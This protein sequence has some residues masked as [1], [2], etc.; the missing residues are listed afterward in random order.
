MT[1][2]L[3]STFVHQAL[4]S[5]DSPTPRPMKCVVFT[6]SDSRTH[7]NDTSGDLIVQRLLQAGHILVHRAM[8]REDQ[9]LMRSSLEHVLKQAEVE[10]ILITGG[11]GITTRDITPDVVKVLSTKEIPG[12]GELFRWLSYAD[13]GSSTIQS[14]ACAHLCGN[15]LVFALPG[16]TGAVSLAMDQIIIPQLDIRHKPCNFA[17]LMPRIRGVL[18]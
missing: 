8:I 14:R 18:S 13:I 15:T 12:F 10:V 2:P 9:A 6:A 3:T 11:T 16:S 17:Q 7:E 1:T 5:P 4:W